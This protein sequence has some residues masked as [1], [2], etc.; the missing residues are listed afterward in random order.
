MPNSDLQ[1]VT[2]VIS[3]DSKGDRKKKIIKEGATIIAEFDCPEDAWFYKQNDGVLP[4][5]ILMEIALQPCGFLT[6]YLGTPLLLDSKNLLF[7]NLDAN[8]EFL[9]TS[10]D[11][12]NKTTSDKCVLL[13]SAK[14]GNMV[15][16]KF[17]FELSVDDKV[18]YKGVTSFGWFLPEDM[19]TQKGLDGGKKYIAD[20]SK[21]SSF[22]L[23]THRGFQLQLFD[24]VKCGDKYAYGSKIVNKDEWFFK[25]HFWLDPVMPGSLGIEAYVQLLEY[26]A[27]SI[28]N[29][30]PLKFKHLQG[31]TS[32]KYRGQLI[33][34]NNKMEVE[35]FITKKIDK[36]NGFE[37]VGKGNI[38]IDGLRMYSVQDLGC[39]CEYDAESQ[40]ESS[41]IQ[42]TNKENAFMK[43]HNIKYPFYA[44][45]MAK[46]IA[47]ADLVIALGK[48]DMIGS[49]GAGGLP[50]H[51]VIQGIEKIQKELGN[52]AYCVNL[53][54]SPFDESLERGNVDLFLK[55]KIKT[56][57]ASAFMT[58][59]E[60]IVR[61]RVSGYIAGKATNKVIAKISRTELAEMFMKPA[62]KKFIDILLKK[63]QIT[64]EQAKMAETIPMADDIAV[65][66]DSGGHTDNR[67]IHVLLPMII[68]LGKKINDEYNYSHKVR[69][70][71]GGGIGCPEAVK[72]VFAMGGE[73]V[74][75]GSINQMSREAGTCDTVRKML[76]NATYSDVTMAPAADMFDQG[77]EL[78]V[79]KKG[80]FFAQRAK[81]LYELFK[82][83]G[84]FEKIPKPIVENVEK[85]I[86]RK[87][88]SEV[89]K[90]TADFYINILKD[91]DKVAKANNNPKIKMSM[92][93]RWYL[94]K[95]SRW[96]NDG[97]KERATDYQ[98]WCGPAIGAFNDY[99]KGSK[100]DPHITKEY[101]SVVDINRSLFE[102]F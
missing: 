24:T 96:A 70:G 67:P 94:G 72:A 13:S 21:A 97:L 33:R 17:S 36:S 41:Q 57:E 18:F 48:N 44:G 76:S 3:I 22:K 71:A 40:L 7:R 59:T 39:V 77:V 68:K 25:C 90:E 52:K 45:A 27:L 85:Q 42:K 54:H 47:S 6:A 23:N 66:S 82:E 29:G 78:Q 2:R 10:V 35:L 12:K 95:S 88:I 38:I 83:Y 73:F 84:D 101:P 102:G 8:V 31:K 80:T 28:S 86:F 51:M 79:L 99:I 89:W 56:V 65:E 26:Y 37:L 14:L 5:S 49:F 58:L 87:S 9:D 61:Y 81:R 62:P 11:L 4:Y 98:I 100:I 75:T 50:L 60:H 16:Q 34:K 92:I 55:Y 69:V 43:A 30:R 93:C 15:V 1:L 63:K 32:W 74:I 46:G 20:S 53:I 64:Q 91:H 19:V